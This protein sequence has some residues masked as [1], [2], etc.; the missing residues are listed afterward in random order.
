MRV[1]KFIRLWLRG[2]SGGI[3][4]ASPPV[5]RTGVMNAAAPTT[6][7][8]LLTFISSPAFFAVL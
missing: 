4:D 8:I 2:G 5:K 3:H 6:V 1:N 7:S